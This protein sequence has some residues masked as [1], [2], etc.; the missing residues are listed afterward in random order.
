MI[1]C[2]I[3][4][5][6]EY[7]GAFFCSECGSQL[8]SDQELDIDTLVIPSRDGNTEPGQAKNPGELAEGLSDFGLYNADRD[9]YLEIP[10]SHEFTIGRFVEGQVITPDVDLN[11]FE[12]YDQ[13]ISRLHATI[14]YVPKSQN[15][16]VVDLGS[17][18]GTFVNGYEIP[19]NS[20]VPI[21]HGDKV[22][23]GK[24]EFTVLIPE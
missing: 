8:L 1:N 19:A 20:E 14:R 9:Q 16:F 5:N 18:N 2:K 21:K 22:K 15:Y 17:A 11:P 23:F 7:R 10:S 12:A 13:G 24:L 6:Q 3:C 4:K